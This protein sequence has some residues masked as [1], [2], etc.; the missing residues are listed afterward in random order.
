MAEYIER[1]KLEKAFD[2]ADLTSVKATRTVTAIG[3]S[4]GKISEM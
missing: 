2:D 1:E 3:G 4:E